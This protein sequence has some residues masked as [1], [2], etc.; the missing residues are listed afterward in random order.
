VRMFSLCAIEILSWHVQIIVFLLLGY[1][2]TTYKKF[3]KITQRISGAKMSRKS[4]LQWR[5]IL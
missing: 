5:H 1:D 4:K 2:R 3:V